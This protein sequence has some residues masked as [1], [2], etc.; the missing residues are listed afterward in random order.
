MKT[1]RTHLNINILSPSLLKLC[2]CNMVLCMAVY[3]MILYIPIFTSRFF[4]SSAIMQCLPMAAYS[5]G[6]IL[7]GPF[8]HKL[9][10]KYSRKKIFTCLIVMG[11]LSNLCLFYL[12]KINDLGLHH[13]SL[14]C[15]LMLLR[16]IFGVSLGLAQQ[17]LLSVIIIDKCDSFVRTDANHASFWFGRIGIAMGFVFAVYLSS[18]GLDA[19]IASSCLLLLSLLLLLFTRL[20][21][22]AP[23][24]NYALL[25]C[26]RFFLTGSKWLFFNSLITIS[27][28]GMLL[29]ISYNGMFYLMLLVGL[30]I[31]MIAERY[32]F[33][34]A[35]LKSEIVMGQIILLVVTF[36][37]LRH[38]ADAYITHVVPILFGIGMGLIGTR[39]LLFFVKLSKHCERG[40]SVSTYLISRECGLS[41]GLCLGY[42]IGRDSLALMLIMAL[43]I[44]ALALL[45][46]NGYTHKWYLKHRNR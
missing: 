31:A 25:N 29:S 18:I 35:D 42:V 11:I 17:M 7:G 45:L 23:D 46:Y 36:L 13:Y 41:L 15:V 28:I 2:L 14:L 44:N 19:M 16:V 22:K 40:T 5:L 21:F 3:V 8:C 10:Q 27:V 34:I 26:D 32:V 1:Q 20:P 30:L 12:F 38:P 39:Y 4:V 37:L 24:E 6:M 9:L 33:D 43:I